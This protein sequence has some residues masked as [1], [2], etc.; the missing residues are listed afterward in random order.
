MWSQVKSNTS[1]EDIRFHWVA[2]FGMEN[3]WFGARELDWVYEKEY[4][5][6]KILTIVYV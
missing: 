3:V 1:T 5:G 4:D 6:G 2:Y